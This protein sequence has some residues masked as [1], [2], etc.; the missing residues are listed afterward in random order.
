MWVESDLNI[1]KKFYFKSI[2][3]KVNETNINYT[4]IH[5]IFSRMYK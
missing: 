3:I 1:S 5:N 2:S 4:A